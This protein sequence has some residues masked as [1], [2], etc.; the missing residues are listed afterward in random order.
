ML[1]AFDPAEGWVEL[2][3]V[4]D[5]PRSTAGYRLRLDLRGPDGSGAVIP[6]TTLAPGAT[7]RVT[8]GQ[9]GVRFPDRGAL[10]LFAGPGVDQAIDALFYGPS[11]LGTRITRG[12]GGWEWAH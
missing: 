3:N 5:T 2:R 11:T 4:G 7:L 12:A 1:S 10:G 6:S 9:L 8:A